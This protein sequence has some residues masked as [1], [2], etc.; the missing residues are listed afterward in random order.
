MFL[1]S[2]AFESGSVAPEL[3][4]GVFRKSLSNSYPWMLVTGGLVFIAFAFFVQSAIQAFIE[5]GPA[6]TSYWRFFLIEPLGWLFWLLLLP[7]I[8]LTFR[9]FPLELSSRS[10]TNL[11][12]QAVAAILFSVCHLY[13]HLIG[14]ALL[15]DSWPLS[16]YSAVLK[17]NFFTF[18]QLAEQVLSYSIIVVM[19]AGMN[20]YR[21]YQQL[22]LEAAEL[23]RLIREDTLENMMEELGPEF[24]LGTFGS[25]SEKIDQDLKAAD[26]LIAKLGNFLRILLQN[27]GEPMVPLAVELELLRSYFEIQKIRFNKNSALIAKVDPEL[28]PCMVPKLFLFSIGESIVREH[29]CNEKASSEVLLKIDQVSES[30]DVKVTVHLSSGLKDASQ[31]QLMGEKVRE[32]YRK[33]SRLEI[34]PSGRGFSLFVSL[35]VVHPL[36]PDEDQPGSEIPESIL[37][38]Q[39]PSLDQCRSRMQLIESSLSSI[40]KHCA[41]VVFCFVHL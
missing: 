33:T 18:L 2:S 20:R 28:L 22:E 40:Q 13:L 29:V 3:N 15:L 11:P 37:N 24:L 14:E 1:K 7:L 35:P 41:P 6:A 26:H 17:F 36:D 21:K 34:D 4:R 12:V 30:L 16:F 23:E 10:K 27:N 38:H 31:L 39:I 8:L 25:I 19:V 32:P 5:T 9:Y